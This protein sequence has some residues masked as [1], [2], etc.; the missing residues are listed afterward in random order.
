MSNLNF[1]I[2]EI[3]NKLKPHEVYSLFKDEINSIFLDSSKEDSE[4]SLYSFIGLNPFKKFSSKGN[5]IF[6]DEKLVL[7]DPFEK[8]EELILEYK[9]N[10]NSEIP[11][12][13]GAMGCY[14]CFLISQIKYYYIIIK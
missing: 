1:E 6:I 9:I 7:G 8:L 12:L 3:E 14:I 13:G 11:F 10:Y 4:F 5:E 2:K